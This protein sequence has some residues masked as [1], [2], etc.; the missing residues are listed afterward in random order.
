MTRLLFAAAIA[1]GVLIAAPPAEPLKDPRVSSAHPFAGPRGAAFT[2][3]L[4]GESIRDATA[5]FLDSKG[6]K[7]SVERFEIEPPNEALTRTK[8]AFDLVFVRFESGFETALGS[9][10]VRLVTPRGLSNAV[11]ILLTD[12]PVVAED[13]AAL[14]QD[15]VARYVHGRIAQRGEVDLFPFQVKAGEVVTFETISGLPAPG[16]AGGNANGFDPSL[17]LYEAS[18]SWFD[19]QRLNRLAFNDEP[20]WVLGQP[21][22]ARLT[23]RFAKAGRYFLKVEA[24]SGQGGPDYSYLLKMFRGSAEAAP[25]RVPKSAWEERDF[26]RALSADRLTQLAGRGKAQKYPA[27][28]TYGPNTEVKLPA[29]IEGALAEP[30][31]AHRSRFRLDGPKDIAIEVQTTKTAPPEFNPIV[32]LLK[33]DEEVATTIFAGRGACTGALFKSLQAKVIVPLRDPGEYTVEVRDT[34]A[35]L[36]DP[37]FQYRVLI[38]QQI[39]HLGSIRVEEDRVNLKPGDAKG[40][41]IS[42][43]REEDYRGAVIVGAEG[44]PPG[45]TALAGADYEPDKDPPINPG[46]RERYTPR[47]ERTVMVFSAAPDAALTPYPVTATLQVRPLVDGKPGAVI[48]SRKIPLMVVAQP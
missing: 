14:E 21:T 36:G 1:I 2:V 46:K 9:H 8:R 23:H 29:A 12:G 16:A 42:F 25:P 30:G 27:I 7:A 39:P 20:L 18:G 3:A 28:E 26:S 11:S 41:R 4:R 32:R 40:I 6:L 34:T 48:H 24:F 44:L 35:D 13:P 15:R 22:D 19:A 31:E 37:G 38:R 17:S 45:V 33:D 47:T 10:A 5:V 43:D